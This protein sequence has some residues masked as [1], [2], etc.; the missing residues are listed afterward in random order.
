MLCEFLALLGG[1]I[2]LLFQIALV[3]DQNARNVGS[4]VLFD[5]GHPVVHV[6]V[7]LLVGDIIDY[8]N[9]VCS[10]VVGGGNGLEALLTGGVPNLE[11]NLLAVHFNSFNFKIDADGRHKVVREHIVSESNKQR[12]LADARAANE[13]NLEKIVA[14]QTCYFR[15]RL[16]IQIAFSNYLLIF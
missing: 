10:L 15:T 12:G 16:T 7:R 14:K 5:L 4:S 13:Q 6:L 2:A 3:S 9:S 1:H 8:Y 11:L